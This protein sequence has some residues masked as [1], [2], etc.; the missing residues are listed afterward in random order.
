MK[1]IEKELKQKKKIEKEAAGEKEETKKLQITL[2][3]NS[4]VFVC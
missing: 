4:E 3:K 1:Q 2:R